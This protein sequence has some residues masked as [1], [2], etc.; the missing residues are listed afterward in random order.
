M[1][2]ENK[3]CWL[4]DDCTQSNCDAF[5]WRRYKLAR[6]YDEANV[7][8]RQ[9]KRFPLK[10]KVDNEAFK[11][12]EDIEKSIKEFVGSGSNLYIYSRTCGN[13]KT[14]WSLRLLQSYFEAIWPEASLSCHGLFIHVPTYLIAIKEY[15]EDRNEYVKH[16]KENMLNADIIIWDDIGNKTTTQYESDSLL[17]II[18]NRMSFG[19][20]NIYTSNLT[21]AEMS[22]FLGD[23][24]AS[25]I[26]H[27]SHVIEFKG[28]DR[29]NT[30]GQ[31]K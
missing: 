4:T 14:S 22:R 26:T 18:D 25:R 7:S 8:M 16:I 30:G 13:G 10:T 20:S 27:A 3:D 15:I 23:R 9:R 11:S 28:E 29:R 5:C 17:S 31:S 6:L 1:I 19:K 24:L 21:D 2:E 12:L